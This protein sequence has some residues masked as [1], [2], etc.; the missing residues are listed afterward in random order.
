RIET[1]V[2]EQ[3]VRCV[4]E[5]KATYHGAGKAFALESCP[6]PGGVDFL[7]MITAVQ[8]MREFEVMED[9]KDGLSYF[10]ER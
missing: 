6:G 8:L 5:G 3:I 2:V 9:S 4:K 10:H 7:E 1:G